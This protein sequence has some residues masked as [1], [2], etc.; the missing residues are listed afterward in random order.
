V[1]I[2][3]LGLAAAGAALLLLGHLRWGARTRALRRRI[4]DA[5]VDIRPAVFDPREVEALPP[6]VRRFFAAALR[7]GQPRLAAVEIA[8]AGRFN[9]DES[10]ERWTAF[11]STQRIVP[12]RPGFVWDARIAGIPGLPVRVHDAYVAGEGI[13]EASLGGLVPLARLRDRHELARGE[14]IRFLA[15]AVWYPTALLPG[16]GLRWEAVDDASA[17][18]ILTDGP[19]ESMLHF[20]FGGDGLID[21]VRAEARGRTVGGRVVPTAWQGRFWNHALRDGMRVPLDGEVAW[22]PAE[23]ARPYWRGHVTRLR[24]EFANP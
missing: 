1:G 24:Y 21:R 7:A 20:R 17:R 13:L 10:G 19:L 6:P 12:R 4:E 3:L 18:A 15:E 9:L 5:R 14:L 8:H 16:P 11:T 23:G 22:L 2:A